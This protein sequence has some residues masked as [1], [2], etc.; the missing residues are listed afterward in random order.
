MDFQL[1]EEQL[2]IQ[3]AI[4][5]TLDDSLSSTVLHAYIDAEDGPALARPSWDALM[6]LGLGG[7]I[8][9]E[10]YGGSGLGLVDAVVACETAGEKAATGPLIE[11]LV[12]GLAIALSD[13]ETAKKNWLPGLA[14]GETVATLAWGDSWLPESWEV[15]EAGG[16]VNGEVAFVTGAEAA[17]LFLVGL[18]GGR[19]AIVESGEHVGCSPLKSSD[20]TRRQSRL[21]FSNAPAMVLDVEVE[22]VFDAALVLQAA[23]ALGGAQQATDMSVAYAKEREQFGQPIGQFQALKHQL[24]QMALEVEPSRALVWYAA[25]AWDEQQGDSRRS[26]ALA[27]AHLTDTFNRICRAAVA[28][29]GGIGYTWE[30]ALNIWI[31]RAFYNYAVFGTPALHRERASNFAG[32]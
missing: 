21:S 8:A 7:L 14:S 24:A 5:G 13:D 10:S 1:S 22:R 31:K 2:A 20:R 32:W 11:H 29:H 19:L 26:A 18:S 28:A 12:A 6:E 27:N 4:R 3:D 17:D 16:T 30:Y 23:D 15:V 25:Y 9:P